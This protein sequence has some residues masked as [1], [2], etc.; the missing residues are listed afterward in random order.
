LPHTSAEGSSGGGGFGSGG[1]P[2]ALARL[3]LCFKEMRLKQRQRDA[4]ALE[5]ALR[6]LHARLHRCYFQL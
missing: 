3:Q 5:H 2:L 1:L 6:A 4:G